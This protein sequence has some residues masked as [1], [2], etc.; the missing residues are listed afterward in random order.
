MEPLVDLKVVQINIFSMRWVLSGVPDTVTVGFQNASYPSLFC[1]GNYLKLSKQNQ[2]GVPNVP[3]LVLPSLHIRPP[4]SI[5]FLFCSDQTSDFPQ[6]NQDFN[7]T[8]IGTAFQVEGG[9]G[10]AAHLNSEI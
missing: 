8:G 7:E 9:E 3:I 6:N 1:A 4:P 2:R 5:L 10:L